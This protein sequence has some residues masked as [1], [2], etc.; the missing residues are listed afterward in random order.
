MMIHSGKQTRQQK[1][2]E[3]RGLGKIWKKGLTSVGGLH[4]IGG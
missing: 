3:G 4:K 2:H 1:E